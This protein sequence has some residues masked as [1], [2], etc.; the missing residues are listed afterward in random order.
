MIERNYCARTC[1][2]LPC[3]QGGQ[4]EAVMMVHNASILTVNPY[5]F[6]ENVQETLERGILQGYQCVGRSSTEVCLETPAFFSGLAGPLP[7]NSDDDSPLSYIAISD[8]GPSQDCGELQR[9]GIVT[10]TASG[11]GFPLPDFTPFISKVQFDPKQSQV[12]VEQTCYL[13]GT[14]GSLIT[15]LSNRKVDGVPYSKDCQ[16][17][18]DYNDSGI[19]SED[20]YPL[21]NTGLCLAVEEYSPSIFVVDCDFANTE[22]CGTVKM[23]YTPQG[24]NLNDASYPVSDTLPKVY[25]NRIIDRGFESVAVSPDGAIAY[26]FL[27][28]PMCPESKCIESEESTVI[29]VLELDTTDPM[30]IQVVGEYLYMGDTPEMWTVKEN[31][32]MDVKVSAALWIGDSD[33]DDILVL[34]RAEGQVKLYIVNFANA[35]NVYDMEQSA[36]LSW[37]S[38]SNFW[39]DEFYV[40]F[41]TKTL[42]LDSSQVEGWDGETVTYKQEGVGLVNDCTVIFGADNEF[43]MGGTGPSTATVVRMQR[44]ISEFLD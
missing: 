36:T 13:K 32:V 17:P 18:I 19:D 3:S 30:D 29:R 1:K 4:V 26:V 5:M 24:V 40:S 42:L 27:Q 34:E 11:K 41:L 2:H 39:M 35:T 28:S 15:G 12:V 22:S 43:G 6:P 44:C 8:R 38:M 14:D 20:I 31:S 23:R 37:E 21:G 9:S 10:P 33:S 16:S 7:T 25:T